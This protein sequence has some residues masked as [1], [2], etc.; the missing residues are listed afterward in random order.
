MPHE[1]I[2]EWGVLV[3]AAVTSLV[4][5]AWVWISMFFRQREDTKRAHTRI[6]ALEVLYKTQINDLKGE[7]RRLDDRLQERDA[8]M[9]DKLDRIIERGWPNSP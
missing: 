1:V 7:L 3:V 8:R 2:K 4:T 6:D 5:A 9:E